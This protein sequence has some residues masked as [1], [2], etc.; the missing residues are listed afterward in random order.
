[1]RLYEEDVVK[2]M[3]SLGFKLRKLIDG[4]DKVWEYVS[5][6]LLLTDI[7]QYLTGLMGQEATIIQL[8]GN[9]SEE[10]GMSYNFP[11][12]LTKYRKSTENIAEIAKIIVDNPEQHKFITLEVLSIIKSVHSREIFDSL[13]RAYTQYVMSEPN[14]AD[15]KILPYYMEIWGENLVDIVTYDSRLPLKKRLC[16]R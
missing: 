4:D 8:F 3:I 1:M 11:K 6:S 12:I 9:T 2:E 7:F 5:D 16:V 13:F 14:H 10:I 15:R